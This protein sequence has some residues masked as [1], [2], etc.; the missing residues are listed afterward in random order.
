MEQFIPAVMAVLPIA[1][2]VIGIIGRQRVVNT[3]AKFLAGFVARYV[4]RRRRD[5]ALDGR[6]STPACGCSRSRRRR[7]PTPTSPACAERG[8][9][10]DRRGHRAPR[11]R[12]RRGDLRGAGAPRGRAS[13]RRSTTP[14]PRT[15]RRSC[16]SPSSTRHRPRR[17]GSSMPLGRRRKYYKKYTH[18]FDVEITP[19]IAESL[20]TFGGTTLARVPEGPARRDAAGARARPPLP[21]DR[22]ARR[23][24]GSRGSSGTCR[25]LGRVRAR[26]RDPAPPAHVAGRGDAAPAAR[27]SAA[28]CP[29]RSCSSRAPIAVGQRFYYL[30]IAGRAPDRGAGSARRRGGRSVRARATSTSRS[31]SRRTSSACSS[32]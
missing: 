28:T 22:R 27:G 10:A 15:S 9:R 11:R 20:K 24:G 23:C 19:Q 6:S 26:R 21:G 7:R 14:P 16:S 1:R 32:T 31:T 25:G 12:A 30:E 3:L 4:P 13:P 17:R 2:T 8:D 5:A 18:V 29:A